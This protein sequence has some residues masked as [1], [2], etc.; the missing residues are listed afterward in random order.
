MRK[1]WAKTMVPAAIFLALGVLL[2]GLLTARDAR[3]GEKPPALPAARVDWTATAREPRQVLICGPWD[4][5]QRRVNTLL[6][7]GWRV[8]PHTQAMAPQAHDAF[9]PIYAVALEQRPKKVAR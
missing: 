8:I 7:E 9:K 4:D 3:A 1:R 2:G 5:A 6:T